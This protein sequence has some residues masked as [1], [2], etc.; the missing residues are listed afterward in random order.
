MK[1]T[2]LAILLLICLHTQ[3]QDL[4]SLFVAMPDSL[5]ALLTKVNREDFG[6][7]LDSKMKAEVKNRFGKTSE[8]QQMTGDYLRLQLSES[9]QVEM[10]LLPLNDSVKVIC[11]VHTY[12]G[13]AED[14]AIRFYNTDW[15]ELAP[16]DFVK[17]PSEDDFYSTPA[18]DNS[19]ATD[20]LRA[21]ADMYLLKA[22]LS[23]TDN[24]LT[25]TY[26]TPD[27]LDKETAKELKAHLK[28][29]TIRRNWMNGHFE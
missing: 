14:S 4:R 16:A 18:E 25:F 11:V 26:T 5:S 15:K 12:K 3:A 28:S 13:P 24:T 19:T 10:K 22:Q 27:Y 29:E 20:N 21:K 1:K 23:E 7:F 17:I 8:M 6:D 9:S 2:I